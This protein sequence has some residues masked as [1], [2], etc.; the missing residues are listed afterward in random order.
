MGYDSIEKGLDHRGGHMW[1]LCMPT[2]SSKSF[3]SGTR[4]LLPHTVTSGEAD[5]MLKGLRS[6]QIF[7]ELVHLWSYASS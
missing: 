5:P 1:R 7:L 6:V 3:S 2:E 4:A